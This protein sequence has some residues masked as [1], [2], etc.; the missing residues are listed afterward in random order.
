MNT[1]LNHI[2]TSLQGVWCLRPLKNQ[3][4]DGAVINSAQ[5][6]RLIFG[7]SNDPSGRFVSH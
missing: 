5:Y 7:Q 3:L 2:H 1:H 6:H 4:S